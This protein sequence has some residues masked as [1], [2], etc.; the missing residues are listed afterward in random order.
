MISAKELIGG[1]NGQRSIRVSLC[2]LLSCLSL[3]S[4]VVRGTDVI[5]GSV[6]V[7]LK[8]PGAVV[9]PYLY[10]QFVEHLGRCIRDGIWAEKLRDRKFL[11]APGKIWHVVKPQGADFYVFHDP[12]GAY[13]GDQCLTMELK[14]TASGE[15]G[16]V[17]TNIMV[18]AGKEYEGYVVAASLG[19][20]TKIM[21]R[22]QWGE[23]SDA[24]QS[25]VVDVDKPRYRKVP[26]RFQAGATTDTGKF[27]ILMF[28][29]G[30]VWIGCVSLMPA[31]N[32][33]G[34]R[35]DTLALIKKLAPPIVRWPGGNFVSGY[36]WKDGIGERDRRPPRWERAWNDVE[37]NDF[38]IDEFLRFCAI[39]KTEP[40]IAVNTGLGSVSDAADEVEYATGSPQS[41]FGRVRAQNGRRSPYPVTWWGIGNEMYGDWQLGHVPVQRYAARHNA[42]VAAMKSRNPAIKVI[43]VG[44]PGQW[45][46]VMLAQC[47]THMDLLSGHHYTER[48]FKVPLS[49]ADSTEYTRGFEAYSGDVAAGIRRLVDDFRR[50]FEKGDQNLKRLRL[51]IDEWGIV[52]D[53]NSAPDGPGVGAFEHY[54]MMGDAVAAARGLHE[55]LR[56]ADMVAM[57]N[58]AQT[59]NVIGTIK[60]RGDYAALDPVGHVLALYRD[61]LVGSL[62]QTRVPENAKIDAIAVWSRENRRLAIGLINYSPA[63]EYAIRIELA[64]ANA[65]GKTTGWQ[66]KGESIDAINIPG[67][68]E[69]VTTR[70]LGTNM[71]VDKPVRLPPCSIT[72]VHLHCR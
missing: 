8:E 35:A 34:M 40:Y 26:F 18:T 58:W 48:K 14:N 70:S 17:Q 65:A 63:A 4:G 12:A 57:A 44:S 15:C 2:V 62:V 33:E 6:T 72:V 43:A 52:R 49:P 1:G 13:A 38:G 16:I 27:S 20:P 32:I 46:D 22:L 59:V 10:G 21:V 55:I 67:K 41:K 25:I 28:Q 53:W 66:V 42:F 64:G 61:K 23:T 9:S 30:L 5:A 36:N 71:E 50:R 47:A 24:S 54:Y 39:T 60:T 3:S 31:D 29:P 56:S 37:D 51:A 68:P 45:N 69:G 19:L 7:D 11:L